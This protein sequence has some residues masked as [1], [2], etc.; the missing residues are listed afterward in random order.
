MDNREELAWLGGIID[1]EGNFHLGSKPATNNKEYLD[2]KVRVS[3]TDMRM[4]RKIS[5]IYTGLNLRFHFAR[6]NHNRAPWKNAI[7]I[8]TTSQRS[9]LK[10]L[11]HVEPFLVNKHDAC[12]TMIEILDHVVSFPITTGNRAG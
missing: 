9:T 3:S 12:I 8:N 1:G 5:E 7:S 10:L 11:H 6:V 2:V 4:I